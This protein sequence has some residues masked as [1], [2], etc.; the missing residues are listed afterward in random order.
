[1]NKEVR[2]RA[3]RL[4]RHAAGK[5][6]TSEPVDDRTWT[7]LLFLGEQAKGHA[8]KPGLVEK[9]IPERDGPRSWAVVEHGARAI[10]DSF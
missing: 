8:P 10:V 6:S 3:E 4:E 5:R 7:E 1:M 9:A 2:R